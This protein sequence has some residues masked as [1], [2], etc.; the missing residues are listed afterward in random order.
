MGDGG[1]VFFHAA[2][3]HLSN[4]SAAH[5]RRLIFAAALRTLN[6]I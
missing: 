3:F 1:S 5:P 4:V 6:V 2:G